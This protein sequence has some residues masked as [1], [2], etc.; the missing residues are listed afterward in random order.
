MRTSWRTSG[1]CAH[2]QADRRRSRR[3]G[4]T[5]PEPTPGRSR[6]RTLDAMRGGADVIFQATFFDGRW[7]GHADFLFRVDRPSPTLGA[8]SYDIADTKLARG[9]QGRRDPPDVR[10]RRPARAAPGHRARVVYVVTGDGVEHRHR[11][12]T[13]RRTT[14]RS[15]PV[16]GRGSLRMLAGGQPGRI[17]TRSTTVASASGTRCASTG[18]AP[19]TIC[20]SWPGCAALDTE[21]LIDGWRADAAE[22]RRA[23]PPERRVASMQ[24]RTLDAAPRSGAPPAPERGYRTSTCFELIQPDPSDTGR[25]LAP[26]P[27][28]SPWDIFFDIEADPWAIGGRPRI[29]ARASSRSR[30]ASRATSHLGPRPRAEEKA[31]FEA[32]ID[33]VMRAARRAIPSM[34]VYHYGGYESGAIKRLMQR[35]A[36][37]RGRGRPAA[38]RRRPRRPAQCRPPGRPRLG[39]VVLAQ[40]DREVLHAGPRGSGHRGRVQR[41]RLRDWLRGRR[42]DDPRRHR[43]LQPRR[44][45][46]DLDAPRL[47]RGAPIAEAIVEF[48]DADWSGR[49]RRDGLPTEKPRMRRGAGLESR[50]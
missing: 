35:H 41:R 49:P 44:L 16:R 14:A 20:R 38:A 10:V 2:G 25:G 15:G 36:H 27:S 21:R 9:G 50:P 43:R 22:P 37:A 18:A 46:L 23:S 28:P 26:C 4:L 19:T 42:P 39:R 13:S 48:P 1:G 47:A 29:P 30:R 11:L 5:T 32:F 12:A 33:L 40:A 45:R 8:W 24:S 6:P 7:R 3:T 31:A 34:H 17:R